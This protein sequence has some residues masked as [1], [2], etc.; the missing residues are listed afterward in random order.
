MNSD[1]T[2]IE[3]ILAEYGDAPKYGDYNDVAWRKVL[4]CLQ[5]MDRRIKELENDP[6]FGWKEAPE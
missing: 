6:A 3:A 4:V 1:L 5:E 2:A